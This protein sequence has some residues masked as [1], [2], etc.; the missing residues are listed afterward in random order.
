MGSKEGDYWGAGGRDAAWDR[1]FEGGQQ[2][3][4]P[5][6]FIRYGGGGLYAG[7][8]VV[9]VAAWAGAQALRKQG[10]VF[11]PA[12]RKLLWF[13]LGVMLVSLLLAFG[14]Y[15]PFYWFL[16]QLPGVSFIRNPAKFM[17]VFVWALVV[18][19]AYGVHG[20]SRCYMETVAPARAG[21]LRGGWSKLAGFR[22]E[23]DDGLPGCDWV[24]PGGMVGVC[25]ITH[26]LGGLPADGAIQLRVRPGILLN[27]ASGAPA[28]LCYCWRRQ[29]GW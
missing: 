24:E 4:P 5:G 9:L 16:Y 21:T 29:P 10:S 27:S 13:W 3:Q 7:I 19:F 23:M 18:V 14:R 8:L 20:L 25:L 11:S 26:E 17:H 6:G 15:A 22:P 12:N 2:G 28:G 1:Y